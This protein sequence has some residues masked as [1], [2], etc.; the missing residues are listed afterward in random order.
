MHQVAPVTA[1]RSRRRMD[2]AAGKI[3]A[4]GE[5]RASCLETEGATLRVAPSDRHNFTNADSASGIGPQNARPKGRLDRL[6]LLEAATFH[7]RARK[8]ARLEARA[9]AIARARRRAWRRSAELDGSE[10]KAEL[11]GDAARSERGRPTYREWESS[12]HL[13]RARSAE[14][15]FD[16]VRS[17][18]EER[19]RVK[20]TCRNSE[21]RKQTIVPIGCDQ[22]WFCKRCRESRARKFRLDLQS[23]MLGVVSLASRAGLTKRYR[24]RAV[25]GRFTQ[26][27]LTFT[28]PHTGGTRER[29]RTLLRVWPRFW[30]LLSDE[31]R[32][33]LE[34]HGS[35]IFLDEYDDETGEQ[36]E[37]T[38]W[39]LVHFLWVVEWTPGSDGLGH[40]HLHAWIFSSYLDHDE[41]L[42]RLWV[43][44]YNDVTGSN[45]EWLSVD[46]RKVHGSS[47]DIS[48]ELCKYLV[49]DWE[50][51]EGGWKPARPEVLAQAYAELD[52]RRM[53]QTSSGFSDF[54]VAVVKSCPCCAYE[55]DAG[56]WARVELE[57]VQMAEREQHYR[58]HPLPEATGPPMDPGREPPEISYLEQAR[59]NDLERQWG[60][61]VPGPHEKALLVEL[62]RRRRRK[63]RPRSQQTELFHGRR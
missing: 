22:A 35:G 8:A 38:L 10:E 31:L 56:H 61:F 6:Q 32:S 53:R 45:V 26:K 55:S 42:T 60:R 63:A 27:F 29:I 14:L 5:A 36:R 47:S 51:D 7:H 24:R 33:K 62:E 25:G 23:K 21:C 19:Y 11:R 57:R 28:I 44:A 1:A 9:A 16:R 34:P 20:L 46:V 39:D 40:P 54:K 18:A 48:H 52:G 41:L 4:Q 12:W 13:S 15:L 50:V 2:S 30:R 59:I 3:P 43:Q 58:L 17:C 37:A 49:K